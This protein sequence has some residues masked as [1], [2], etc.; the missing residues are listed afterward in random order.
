MFLPHAYPVHVHGG[1]IHRR[2]RTGSETPTDQDSTNYHYGYGIDDIESDKK[3][4]KKKAIP[5]ILVDI[6]QAIN[7]LPFSFSSNSAMQPPETGKNQC[8]CMLMPKF[9]FPRALE[10]RNNRHAAEHRLV[11]LAV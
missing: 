8:F 2:Q 5:V 3:K 7:H 11:S 6:T 4:K 10:C 9:F 1:A